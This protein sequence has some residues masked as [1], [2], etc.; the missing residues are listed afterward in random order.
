MAESIVLYLF[1]S[2]RDRKQS[3]LTETTSHSTPPSLTNTQSNSGPSHSA[4]G[5]KGKEKLPF[6]GL[7]VQVVG[8]HGKKIP[9]PARP[10]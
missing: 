4:P 8:M 1:P 6:V 5:N 10:P 2:P 3:Y 7:R 9:T